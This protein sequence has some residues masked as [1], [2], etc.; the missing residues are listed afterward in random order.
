MNSI[1]VFDVPIGRGPGGKR[2]EKSTNGAD[3]EATESAD[4]GHRETAPLAQTSR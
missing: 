3:S 1:I 4:R 2:E